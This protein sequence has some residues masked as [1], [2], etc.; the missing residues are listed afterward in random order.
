MSAIL[1]KSTPN[2]LVKSTPGMLLSLGQTGMIF[3]RLFAFTLYAG[4]CS[5]DSGSLHFLCVG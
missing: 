3:G 5:R 2:I 4:C 1:D